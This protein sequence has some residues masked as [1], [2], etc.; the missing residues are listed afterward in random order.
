METEL[1]GI[2][3]IAGAGFVMALVML[4]RQTVPIPDKLTAALA[5][6]VGIVLNVVLRT[7]TDATDTVEGIAEVPWS[8]T[9]L[10]GVLAGMAA[11]GLWS[12]GKVLR[13]N[14]S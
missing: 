7:A 12:T 8:A 2:G 3:G 13:R 9:V 4:I 1:A 6:V 10:T 14:G 5:V 11:S